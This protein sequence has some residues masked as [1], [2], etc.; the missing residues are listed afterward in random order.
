MVKLYILL[1]KLDENFFTVQDLAILEHSEDENREN[2]A[3]F[4]SSLSIK[5]PTEI[6]LF[7]HLYSFIK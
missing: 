1:S 7:Y 6:F 3:N 2:W 5:A 4:E